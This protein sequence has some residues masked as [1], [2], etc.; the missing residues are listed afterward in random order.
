M[1][2]MVVYYTHVKYMNDG[3]FLFERNHEHRDEHSET[4]PRV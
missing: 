4:T 3:Y 1:R 2:S